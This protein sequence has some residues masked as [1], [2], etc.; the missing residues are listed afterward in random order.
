MNEDDEKPESLDSDLDPDLEVLGELLDQMDE[1][2]A[3]DLEELDGF[4]AALHCAP[5]VVP[6]SEYM[7]EV[8]GDGFEN[9]EIF[10]NDDGV[11]LFLNLV[12]HHS[13]VVANA[14]AANDFEPLLLEDEEGNAHGNNWA[15]G[16]MRGLDMRHDE[17]RTLLDNEE[18]FKKLMPI[19][20]LAN[21]MHPDPEQRIYQE[22][23]SDEQREMLL[24]GMSATV[25]ELYQHFAAQR[26]A[27]SIGQLSSV[28]ETFGK[29]GRNDTCY[30]GSGK[31][32]KKCCGGLT[33]N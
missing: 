32:Y 31:K 30:C 27:E 5:D 22:P 29:I 2:G 4:L 24:Q 28:P 14:F 6:P 18:E 26:Q 13:T 16:F 19:L 8:V 33:V 11:K 25:A 23:I 9:E 1:A 10:P 12:R 21:E 15:I 7:P 20:A 3:M 17:W